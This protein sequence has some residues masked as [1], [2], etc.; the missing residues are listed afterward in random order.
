MKRTLN[1]IGIIMV[2]TMLAAAMFTRDKMMNDNAKKSLGIFPSDVLEN[3]PERVNT[4]I[5]SARAR[6]AE[7]SA[8]PDKT[9]MNFVRP[10]MDI[11]ADLDGV[12]G[13]IE[14]LDNV[15]HSDQ[16]HK[17]M[18]A[19]LPPLSEYGSDMARNRD[20]YAGFK[21][22][23][24]RE[25]ASMTP[26]Q[27][28]LVDDAIRNFEIAGVNLPASDQVRL[29][30]ISS[31]LA[32]LSNDFSNNIISANQKFKMKISDVARLGDMP[33]S[34]R[35]TARTADGW[36]FSLLDPSYVAFMTYV[37]DRGLRE[38]MFHARVTRAPENE[39][40]IPEIL[41]L[42]Q[43]QAKILGYDDIAELIFTNRAAP[44]PAAATEFLNNLAAAAKPFAEA[45]W[46]ELQS[47]AA[48]DGVNPLQP[49]DTAYYSRIV[50]KEKY[51]VDDAETKPYFELNT[52]MNSMFDV[53][54]D[55]FGV[56][57]AA[58]AV[59]LWHPDARYYDVMRDGRI[60]GGFYADLTARESKASGAHE[61]TYHARYI[62]A[63]G[64]KHLPEVF[65]VADFPPQSDGAPS[66]LTMYNVSVLFHETGHALMDLLSRVDERDLSGNNVDWDVIEFPSQFLESFWNSPAV[67]KRIGRDYRTGDPIPDELIA[68]I[69][70][71]ENFQKGMW[72]VRQLELG[73]FDLD[74]HTR[75]N[76]TAADVQ[77]S[78]DAV[79]A[80][81][82]VIPYMPYDKFQDTFGH[83]FAGGYAAGYYS[84]LWAQ[85][86]AADA[87]IS[88]GGDLFNRELARKYRDTVLADGGS[89]KMGDIYREFLGHD[90]DPMSLLKYYGLR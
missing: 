4:A 44:S 16:T 49:W 2:A 87:Y 14:H 23:K 11:G 25:Y 69:R 58:R 28:K 77:K 73:L 62:D 17:I 57:F 83:I 9:Y 88:F 52:T 1:I 19:I 32:K 29:K 53:L 82:A 26:A 5:A 66:L 74:I 39:K 75:H 48:V 6:V 90:P 71:A 43:E 7:L 61:T 56:K 30:K 42:R 67:L 84:Y 59:P 47:R 18:D 34:D 79:R 89:K 76:M 80:R 65:I 3:A 46:A 63:S 55:A 64:V 51:N 22:I 54:G 45:N 41:A 15:N 13:P 70:R 36:E 85:V 38:K 72:I 60:I 68:R 27:K 40:L 81:V 78:L 24:A 37:L 10:L 35:A 12:V 50:Q 21:F 20:V 31:K 33:E 86:L 8:I